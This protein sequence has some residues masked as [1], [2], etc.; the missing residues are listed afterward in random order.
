MP[1]SEV[2]FG[3]LLVLLLVGLSLYFGRRQLVML[4]LMR[5][6]ADVSE[7]ELRYEISK[8]RR[9]LVSCVLTFILGLTL[10][11]I[12]GVYEGPV[13]QIAD[14]RAEFT[15]EN[16]PPYTQQERTILRVWGWLWIGF[17][18]V[19]LAVMILAGVDVIATRR[20]G[21]EQY[22][23]LQADRRAMI[24]HQTNRLRQERNGQG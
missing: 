19:L 11:L 6:D 23:R 1:A 10:A 8:A 5:Q 17:L 4:R 15:A 9:R 20:Y 3:A 24:E 12:L 21:R 22:R 13:Q 16:S 2:I 14:E 18:M 7:A